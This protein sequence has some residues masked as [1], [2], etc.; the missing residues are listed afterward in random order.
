M[1]ARFGMLVAAFLVV[2]QAACESSPQNS[3]VGAWQVDDP[4]A[5][6]TIEFGRAGA[7]QFTTFGITQQGTYEFTGPN[8]MEWQ[9]S[10]RPSAKFKV[11][12]TPKAI[13]LTDGQN[14]TVIFKRK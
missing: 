6:I 13:E 10:G 7:L 2:F 4:A 12:A 8:E 9:L 11:S 14:Q 3:I 5:K 1:N